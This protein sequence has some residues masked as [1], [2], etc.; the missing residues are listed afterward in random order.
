MHGARI[1]IKPLKTRAQ[2]QGKITSQ[3]LTI[4]LESD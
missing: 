2:A 3:G 1:T 4:S